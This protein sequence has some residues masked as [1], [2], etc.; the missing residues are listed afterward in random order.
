MK[1]FIADTLLYHGEFLL[2]DSN[3]ITQLISFYRR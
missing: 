2:T 3:T 1:L